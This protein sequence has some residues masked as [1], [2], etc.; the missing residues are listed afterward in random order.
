MKGFFKIL[1]VVLGL[2]L[3]GISVAAFLLA[4]PL[5]T[6][7]AGRFSASLGKSLG[8]EVSIEGFRFV[9][10]KMGFEIDTVDIGNPE[11]FEK[12]TALRCSKV[13]IQPQ[14]RSLFADTVILRRVR[15]EG[16]V[17]HVRYRPGTGTNIAALRDRAETLSEESEESDS[18]VLVKT[19]EVGPSEVRITRLEV[20]VNVAAFQVNDVSKGRALPPVKA[21]SVLFR[22]MSS[23]ILSVKGVLDPVEKLIAGG[24]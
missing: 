15:I 4:G 10:E 23:E 14:F 9:P 12:D 17:M 24:A 8:S 6:F 7:A 16:G 13:L 22:T 1:A 11:P 19:L 18:G 2:I 21:F 5:S 20:P 3:I